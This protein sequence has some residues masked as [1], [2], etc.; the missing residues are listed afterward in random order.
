MFHDNIHKLA[1]I[2]QRI[3]YH[4]LRVWYLALMINIMCQLHYATELS[5][6]LTCLSKCYC[7]CIFDEINIYTSRLWIKQTVLHNMDGPHQIN[8]RPS[9][10]K[11][12]GP[13]SKREFCLQTQDTT[14]ILPMVST[15]PP[16]PADF[17][18]PSLHNHINQFLTIKSS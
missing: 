10:K 17:R 4:V 15:L 2:A 3:V 9:E 13:P 1:L 7:E 11:D 12:G 5:Y 6:L 18:L 8:W 14:S 16:Y